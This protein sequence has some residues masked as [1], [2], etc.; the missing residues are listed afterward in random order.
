MRPFVRGWPLRVLPRSRLCT[1]T[2]LVSLGCGA[3][4]TPVH[5]DLLGGL[6]QGP[7]SHM[8][9]AHGPVCRGTAVAWGHLCSVQAQDPAG[10]GGGQGVSG[11]L[12]RGGLCSHNGFRVGLRD[13]GAPS[14]GSLTPAWPRFLLPTLRG[15]HLVTCGGSPCPVTGDV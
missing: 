1:G 11:A 4:Q 14:W 9:A 6:R 5:P 12:G 15:F 2:E 3:G 10:A 8:L 13:T 7:K